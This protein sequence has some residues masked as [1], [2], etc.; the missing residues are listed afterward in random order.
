MTLIAEICRYSRLLSGLT[1]AA[2]ALTLVGIVAVIVTASLVLGGLLAP[3]TE[4]QPFVLAVDSAGDFAGSAV[5]ATVWAVIPAA[6]F[7]VIAGFGLWC[8]YQVSSPAFLSSPSVRR[9]IRAAQHWIAV[10]SV[11]PRQ[12]KALAGALSPTA[13]HRVAVDT[14]ADLA[15]AAPR[16]N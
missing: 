1:F 3:F 2:S 7:A 5:D 13:H 16:L 12:L 4:I 14:A 6:L 8:L 15:G 9:I 11:S 10:N